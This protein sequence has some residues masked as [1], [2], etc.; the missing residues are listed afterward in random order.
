[1]CAKAPAVKASLNRTHTLMD[2]KFPRSKDEDNNTAP[3]EASTSA[4]S[5]SFISSLGSGSATSGGNLGAVKPLPSLPSVSEGAH[6]DPDLDG[7]SFVGVF[8]ADSSS[9]DTA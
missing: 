7:L 9:D 8:V 3:T 1:M 6:V 5:A 2:H 4:S